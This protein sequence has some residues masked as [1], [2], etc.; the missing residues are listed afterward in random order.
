MLPPAAWCE[1]RSPN[2]ARMEVTFLAD[3]WIPLGMRPARSRSVS[4]VP[5]LEGAEETRPK[6]L[7]TSA[8]RGRPGFLD[9]T[10]HS[11]GACG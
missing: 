1:N 6:A 7:K 4:E 5:A 11:N 2:V 3:A 9:G 8:G 10:R